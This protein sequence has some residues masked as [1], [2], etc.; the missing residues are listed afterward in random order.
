MRSRYLRQAF[1]A[2]LYIWFNTIMITNQA[3]EKQRKREGCSRRNNFPISFNNLVRLKNFNQ[4]M[5]VCLCLCLCLCL[6]VPL[7]VG[8]LRHNG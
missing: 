8:V 2:Q 4:R 7:R 6:H 3:S 1:L 5:M